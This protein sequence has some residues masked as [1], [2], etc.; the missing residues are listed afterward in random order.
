[1][2]TIDD[3]KYFLNIT[4]NN[5]DDFLRKLIDMTTAKINNLCKRNVS[6]ARIYEV[7][8][9]E[10]DNVIWLKNY[11]VEKVEYIKYRTDS[12]NFDNDLFGGEPIEDNV[13]LDQT[14]G[15]VIL[16]NGIQLPYGSSNVKIKYYAGYVE[17]APDPVNELPLDLKWVAL[18]MTAESYLKSF[19]SSGNENFT[20]RLGLERFDKLIK[21]EGNETKYSFIFRDEDYDSI[22]SK[23]YT[24]KI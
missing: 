15:K 8:D 16:L 24:I 19:Q 13:Y 22:L 1:M 14:S 21:S 18:M 9:G 11:P 20:K 6:Y 7:I 4:D 10:G 3:V 17:S 2:V 5:Q 23:Y 12:G